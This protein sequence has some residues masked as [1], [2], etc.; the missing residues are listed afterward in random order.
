M[1]ERAECVM[2]N[3]GPYIVAA[4][5]TLDDILRRMRAH[6]EKKNAACC[7]SCT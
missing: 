1:G 2:L 6:H 3:K 5:Q 7:A 4:V